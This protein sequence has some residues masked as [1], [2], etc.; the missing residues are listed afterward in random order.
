MVPVDIDD[1]EATKTLINCEGHIHSFVTKRDL[2]DEE[3]QNYQ[4]AG[5]AIGFI[6]LSADVVQALIQAYQKHEQE[7]VTKLWEFLFN[8]ITE[9]VAIQAWQLPDARCI[10]IDTQED[11]EAALQQ[12]QDFDKTD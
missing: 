7:L 8:K 4:V 12:Y 3:K 5:E 2:T 1:T 11:Y 9:E 10:E 6:Q